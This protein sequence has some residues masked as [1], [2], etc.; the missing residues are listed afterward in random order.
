MVR[1]KV[2]L[3]GLKINLAKRTFFYSDSN[4]TKGEMIAKIIGSTTQSLPKA[5][6]SSISAFYFISS[7]DDKQN[8]LGLVSIL[9]VL[10]RCELL[11][12]LGFGLGIQV[13]ERVINELRFIDIN[14]LCI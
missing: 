1:L 4:F 14:M 10:I 6:H 9:E 7:D 11:R 2:L 13:G 3:T 8:M 12:G 5:Y